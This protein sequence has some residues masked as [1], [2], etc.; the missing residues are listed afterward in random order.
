MRCGRHNIADMRAKVF[1]G[2]VRLT[3]RRRTRIPK[4]FLLSPA[5]AAVYAAETAA[6]VLLASVDTFGGALALGWFAGLSYSRQNM[7]ITAP[8]YAL[9]VIAFSPSAWTLL[10]VAVPLA[11]FAL[12]YAVFYRLRKNVHILAGTAAALVSE[13]PHAVL[14]VLFGGS[15]TAG[16][17]SFVLAGAFAFVA[18]TVCYAVL[19]RG[20]KTRFTPD[21]LIAAGLAVAVFCYAAAEVRVQGLILVFVFIPFFS[22]LLAYGAGSTAAFAFA[23]TAGAGGTLAFAHPLFLAYSAACAAAVVALRPFTKW[24]SAAGALIVYVAAWLIFG[25]DGWGWQNLICTA[26]GAGAYLLLP[27]R[28]CAG[29]FGNGRGNAALSGVVNRCRTE[30]SARLMSVSKVFYDMSGTLRD[31][32][33]GEGR[34]TP[35]R[36]AAEVAKNYCGRCPEREG[37]FAALGGSTA[38]V[39]RPMADAAMLRGK[40]TIL[41]MPPFIT[42]RCGKMHNLAAVVSSAA[43]AYRKRTEEAGELGET[44]RLMSEQF[45][46]VSL[47]LD[48]LAGECGESVR[49]G[50]EE[51]EHIADELLRHNIVAEEIVV[52]GEGA[53]STVALTVR[54]SDADKAVLPR[55]VSSCLG[56]KLERVAVTPRGSEAVVHLAA[57][58]VFEVAYGSA[59]KRRE[60]ENVSGDAKTVLCPSRRRRLF[61]LSDG[62]GSGERAAKASRDAI[63]MV[64]NFYRA[65]FDNA[66]I[67]NLVNKLLCLTSDENFSSIDIAVID[68]ASGGLDIIKMGAVPTFIMHKGSVEIVSCAAP[69]AGIIERASPVTVRRQLY[70]GDMVFIMSDG[71]YDALDEQGVIS[72]IQEAATSNPQILAD[73]LL[74]KALSVGAKDDCT[75]LV[76]RLYTR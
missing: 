30:L 57:C 22:M 71:V 64:E 21:E 74:E 75:V 9:A 51:Q 55:I 7:L 63:S 35:E 59:G 50:E 60:G 49:F 73:R 17:L 23:V 72:S 44:K 38:S 41:D 24:A 47:V 34:Y 19:F 43:E 54:A 2:A 16:I 8:V 67:L 48:S 14:S 39:I 20:I 37:C 26:L 32:D 5:K 4:R 68:T 42:G 70:D 18:Q 28:F 66:V 10:Y 25:G 1:P 29:V 53:S 58:S 40:V 69:P 56:V 36:L 13:L 15:V 45:A 33:S 65:G 52:G 62:M 3:G 46:G 31:L 6:A 11:V 27:Q 12:L 76:L 61:A